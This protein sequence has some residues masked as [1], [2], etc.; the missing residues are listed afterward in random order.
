MRF[1]SNLH[2]DRFGFTLRD[3]L[4]GVAAIGV[5]LALAMPLIQSAR[6]TA[7]KN[8]CVN[9]MKQL[10]LSLHNYHDY[11]NQ[12]PNVTST[13]IRGVA[14]ASLST[15]S[16]SGTGY[17]WLVSVLPY[18]NS[19]ASLHAEI[20]LASKKFTLSPFDP[21]VKR[22]VGIAS[23]A[24][25]DFAAQELHYFH[26]PSQRGSPFAGA[27]EFVAIGPKSVVG[28]NYVAL[29]ATHLDCM[30]G[31]PSGPD[32]TPPNGVIVPGPEIVSL[33]SIVG[34]KS[35][36]LILAETREQNYTSW[37][38]GSVGW[39]V[40]ADAVSIK[41]VIDVSGRL[42]VAANGQTSLN[43]RPSSNTNHRP[44]L[45]AS[46]HGNITI[47]WNW[48]PS[49][50]HAA[51]SIV[52]GLCDGSVRAITEDIDTTLYIQL[53]DRTRASPVFC[54]EDEE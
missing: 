10:V 11:R 13:Q 49:S 38:D 29:S 50:E 19:N 1:I 15:E 8:N 7:R 6:E 40:A 37:Y 28:S 48:G 25:S 53:V 20:E 54:C 27:P 47:D 17:H 46:L 43:L 52:H 14:P 41:P 4:I 16:S 42:H 39:V 31:D 35:M 36:T 32:H 51:A 34:K 18:L 30:L 5:L 26:C 44:Y 23:N 21:A 45:P 22:E 2:H 33:K 12:F 9:N 24:A 3:M